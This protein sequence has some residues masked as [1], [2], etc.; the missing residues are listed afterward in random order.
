[1]YPSSAKI[2]IFS[3]V[4]I[5]MNFAASRLYAA[6]CLRPVCHQVC[7]CV[8]WNLSLHAR[9]RLRPACIVELSTQRSEQF[10][11]YFS[12]S[13]RMIQQ[14][15]HARLSCAVDSVSFGIATE[16]FLF[17]CVFSLRRILFDLHFRP[18]LDSYVSTR[19]L[20]NLTALQLEGSVQLQGHRLHRLV[21][22]CR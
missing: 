22:S 20:K 16:N 8:L 19:V 7:L 14:D 10:P 18:V 9:C 2:S 3:G 17:Q 1:M 11:Q 13:H 15:C 5:S 21:V 6:K 12:S 4:T